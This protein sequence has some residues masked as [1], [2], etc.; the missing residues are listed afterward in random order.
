MAYSPKSLIEVI[1]HNKTK[2]LAVSRIIESNPQALP[3]IPKLV[4]DSKMGF[5]STDIDKMQINRGILETIHNQLNTNRQNNKNIVKLFPDIEMSIQILVSSILSPKKMT[6]I[7]LLYKFSP[8]LT[9][10]PTVTSAIVSIVK[11]YVTETYELE[12]KLPEIVREALFTSGSYCMAVVPEASVDELVNSDLIASY[13]TEAFKSKADNLIAKLTDGINITPRLSPT[14]ELSKTATA[15]EFLKHITSEGFVKVTDNTGVFRFSEMKDKIAKQLVM[16]SYKSGVSVA[17]ESMDKIEYLDIFRRRGTAS[18]GTSNVNVIKT[19][20]ETYRSSIGTPMVVRIPSQSII[21][22][23][24]PGNEA[25]HIGYLVLLDENGKP[26]NAEQSFNESDPQKGTGANANTPVQIAYKNL[27][28][29]N[30]SK[31]NVSDLFNMYKDILESQLYSSI[32]NSLYS[33]DIKIANK[34]DI[35]FLMFS[36]ALAEQKT[37]ILYIPKELLTYFS[38]YFDEYGVGKSILDNLSILCSLRAI[39]LFARVM[40]QAK[41][42]ID[43]TKVNISLSPEDPDPEKTIQTVQD[44]VL[45][46]RQNFFPLGI[47]NPVDLINWI[48]RAGLQFAYSNN[49]L[50][51]DVKIDFE[52]TNIVHNVPNNELEESLRKQT[53]QALGLPP[54]TV[55][56]AFSPEFA[57]N[58]VNNNVLMSKRVMIYQKALCKNLS[59]LVGLFIYNDEELRGKLRVIVEKNAEVIFANLKEEDKQAFTKDKASFIER[60]IDAISEHITVELPKPEN[61]NMTNLAQEFDVYKAG[62]ESVV[63]SMISTD[64][65]S[66]D[67]T[68]VLSAHIDTIRNVFKHHLLRQWCASNNYFPEAMAIGNVDKKDVDVMMTSIT[69]HLTGTM[70]NSTAL[71][72]MMQK[73]KEA[74]NKDLDGIDSSGADTFESSTSS[75]DQGGGNTG[76]TEGEEG[77]TGDELDTS[78]DFN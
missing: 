41:N 38:F 66:E 46:L 52:T 31:V 44:G 61:T 65:F 59:K 37:S 8:K 71:L 15:E 73:F 29:D 58:V 40:S 9:I 34:N 24:V 67:I 68:G 20:N 47:N 50:I 11:E 33:K 14:G 23:A 43:V 54:E 64:I 7:Q 26:L 32:Q 17:T 77:D 57:V 28:A 4:A 53:F 3:I 49:P 25:E 12:E 6:D 35:F 74:L 18:A 10:A 13:S 22:V 1:Q 27:V 5:R 56:N 55:D 76:S 39:L 45:K 51:P 16:R 36:R 2:K 19:R 62:L 69:G 30:S 70:S 75:V 48:Q 60:Y 42:A 21:P 78:L 72:T 63:E